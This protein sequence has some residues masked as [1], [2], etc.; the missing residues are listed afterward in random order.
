MSMIH[1]L[2]FK[3]EL[4][5]VLSSIAVLYEFGNCKWHPHVCPMG[6]LENSVWPLSSDTVIVFPRKTSEPETKLAANIFMQ[7]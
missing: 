3:T 1:T 2:A 7:S 6:V 4:N 5:S